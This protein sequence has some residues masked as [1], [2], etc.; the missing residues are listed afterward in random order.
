MS[1][2][3]LL[4]PPEIK[5]VIGPVI[6]LA[7]PIQDA[8]DWQSIAVEIISGIDPDILIASPR[9][10]YG[11]GEFVYE[12]QVD[13]ESHYLRRAAAWGAIIF[14]LANQEKQTT[15]PGQRFP[16]PYAQTTR[17]ELGEWRA[18][19]RHSPEINLVVGI[20]TDFSNARYTRRR[21]EQDTPDVP[22]LDS[23]DDTCAAAVELIKR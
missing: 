9:K 20:D 17:Q 10:N 13:W 4:Q 1:N 14:W 5:E 16:R 19:K 11:P 23:L 6:F 8:P 15:E 3:N 2:P 7:G 21:L 18:E 22:I 12:S